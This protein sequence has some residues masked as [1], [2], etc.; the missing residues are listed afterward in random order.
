MCSTITSELNEMLLYCKVTF[1]DCI[2]TILVFEQESVRSLDQVEN[3]ITHG[4]NPFKV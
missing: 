2:S 4:E 3:L 1:C